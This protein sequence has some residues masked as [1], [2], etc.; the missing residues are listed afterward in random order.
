MQVAIAIAIA[1]YS[2]NALQHIESAKQLLTIFNNYYYKNVKFKSSFQNFIHSKPVDDRTMPERRP[3]DDQPMIVGFIVVRWRPVG[4]PAV[5]AG[6]PADRRRDI[7]RKFF[8]L[9]SESGRPRTVTRQR[10]ADVRCLTFTTWFK[11]EKIR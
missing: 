8:H 3:A 7:G 4:A 6:A 2:G 10:P 9:R 11:V 5:T 1:I